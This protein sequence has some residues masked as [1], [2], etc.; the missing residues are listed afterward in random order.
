MK[1][2][3]FLLLFSSFAYGADTTRV[4]VNRGGVPKYT[5]AD[6]AKVLTVTGSPLTTTWQTP[7]GGGGGVVYVDT[8]N[9]NSFTLGGG[10]NILSS[11]FNTSSGI[12][13]LRNIMDGEENTAFGFEAG[14]GII[15]GGNNIAIG[16]D[17]LQ[18][19]TDGTRNTVVGCYAL[20]YAQSA[21][22]NTI[23]GFRA[24]NRNNDGDN[25]TIIGYNA[26]NVTTSNQSWNWV[27]ALGSGSG[28]DDPDTLSNLFICGK[29][30][31]GIYDVFFGDGYRMHSAS[32]PA[33]YTIH[34]TGCVPQGNDLPGGSITIAGGISTGA[35]LGGDIIF[36]SSHAGISGTDDNPLTR[37]FLFSSDGNFISYSGRMNWITTDTGLPV[38]PPSVTAGGKGF[39]MGDSSVAGWNGIALGTRSLA[40][41]GAVAIGAPEA[42]GT[43]GAKATGD[44]AT[45]VGA[46]T[47]A[48][49]FASLAQGYS[50]TDFDT[51]QSQDGNH[52]QNVVVGADA[53]NQLG[54][55]NSTAVG[56]ASETDKSNGT[57]LGM[58]ARTKGLNNIALGAFSGYNNTAN[59]DI[60]IQS[61][62][63]QSTSAFDSTTEIGNGGVVTAR[64]AREFLYGNGN[65]TTTGLLAVFA[66]GGKDGNASTFDCLQIAKNG[67]VTC[68]GTITATNFSGVKSTWSVNAPV[69]TFNRYAPLNAGTPSASYPTV[70]SYSN[71]VATIAPFSGTIKNLYANSVSGSPDGTDT[72]MIYKNGIATALFAIYPNGV[73]SAS[74][75]ISSV[76]FVAGDFLSVAYIGGGNLNDW[77]MSVEVDAN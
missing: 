68:G 8:S 44:F 37:N 60:C 50:A 74:N 24:L 3:F 43:P 28:A 71:I 58:N 66:N 25:N 55:A 14:L 39:A 32:T 9:N 70:G 35:G 46:S 65:T 41:T 12:H 72:I 64:N 53:S 42:S 27:I 59:Y 13:A 49:S 67:N 36:A 34:G 56:Y 45:A 48:R 18:S 54:S 40:G 29:Q 7:S 61:I 22:N 77:T 19:D 47:D 5:H 73:K 10:N 1:I 23:I 38:L 21:S 76:T 57:A 2:L 51:S 33:N 30:G 15:H 26:G 62:T 6:S 4:P 20:Q 52:G 16:E 11:G 17:A 75:T 63:G 69:G 31:H